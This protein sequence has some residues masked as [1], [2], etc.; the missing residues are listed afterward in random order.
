M[1]SRADPV[2]VTLVED[3]EATRRIEHVDR[4]RS[5]G[6]GVPHGAGEDARNAEVT[7]QAGNGL[8]TVTQTAAKLPN[9]QT[10]EWAKLI[11]WSTP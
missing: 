1:G 9:I 2:E 4:D 8:V 10:S 3:G 7:G 11:S 6:G 5:F